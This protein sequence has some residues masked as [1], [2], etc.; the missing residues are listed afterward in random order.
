VID[1]KMFSLKRIDVGNRNM[2][3]LQATEVVL[4]S[5]DSARQSNVFK[6]I[7]KVVGHT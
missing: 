4:N 6:P 5:E 3:N 1:N 2:R 7:A